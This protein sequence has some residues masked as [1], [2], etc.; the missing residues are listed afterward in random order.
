M[1]RREWRLRVQDIL[2]QITLIQEHRAGADRAAFDA[3][4]MLQAAVMYRIG[5]IGE[6]VS[7]I[8]EEL[9]DRHAQIPWRDIRNMRNVLTHVY[10]GVDLDQVWEVIQ[11]DLKPLAEQLRDL[12]EAERGSG[13]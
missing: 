13:A 6:A 10:F 8:P 1:Q 12:I 11:H 2:D 5:V 9:K 3:D 7:A 4:T